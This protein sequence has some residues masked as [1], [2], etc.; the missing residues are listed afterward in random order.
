M[1]RRSAQAN[2]AEQAVA[3]V[4]RLLAGL[5][6]LRR[7]VQVAHAAAGSILDSSQP[8]QGANRFIEDALAALPHPASCRSHHNEAAA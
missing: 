3:D 1:V 5:P 8:T 4:S 7:L 6:A 2:V